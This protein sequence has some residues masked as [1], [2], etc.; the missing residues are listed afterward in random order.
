MRKILDAKYTDS[1]LNKVIAEQCQHR[2]NEECIKL[3][4][5]LKR[6]GDISK[7]TLGT[8]NTAPVDLE[9]NDN[10]K[11]VC[12]RPYP[13]P[14]VHKAM[15]KKEVKWLGNLVVIKYEN[16]S[17][18]GAPYFDQPEG[19]NESSKILEWLSELK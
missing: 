1:Y 4:A 12:L 19:E 10:T 8:F 17:E 14:R 11:P 9:L 15:F 7:G 2:T 5:L 13:V 3:L 16:D 6:F 18:W